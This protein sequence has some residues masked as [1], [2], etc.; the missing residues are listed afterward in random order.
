LEIGTKLY[1][2]TADQWRNW[3]EQNGDVERDIWLVFYKKGSGKRRIWLSE[4]IE[5]ALCFGWVD[6]Q[7]KGI[8]ETSYALRF[9]PRGKRSSWSANNRGLARKLMR[10]G[11]MSER[12]RTVLPAD[13]DSEA[14]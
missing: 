6:S 10:E 5:E 1:V 4:A 14:I 11:R 2:E 9:T 8:D 7:T 13:W 12:G 3:L